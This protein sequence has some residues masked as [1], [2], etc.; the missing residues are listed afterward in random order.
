MAESLQAQMESATG[1]ITMETLGEDVTY[2]PNED[3]GQDKTIRAVVH[4]ETREQIL[5]EGTRQLHFD[6]MSIRIRSTDNSV[7]HVS[8]DVWG[9]TQDT[10]GD[11]VVIDGTT[12]YVGE[13][14]QRNVGGFHELRLATNKRGAA[15]LA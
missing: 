15:F 10:K 7:G 1:G 13:V 4:R 12:W 5:G 11:V 6:I 14:E 3:A 2:R 9:A 8:P